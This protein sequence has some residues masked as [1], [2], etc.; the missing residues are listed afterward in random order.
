LPEHIFSVNATMDSFAP[1]PIDPTNIA[2]VELIEMRRQ[3]NERLQKLR[4]AE[5]QNSM[6]KAQAYRER[7]EEARIALK[8]R[9]EAEEAERR[10]DELRLVS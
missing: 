4:Q 7:L 5:R 9:A 6:Q 1:G 2:S 8:Q 10:D 3:K